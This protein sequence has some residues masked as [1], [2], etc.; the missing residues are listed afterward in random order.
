[1]IVLFVVAAMA[2]VAPAA[3]VGPSRNGCTWTPALLPL[4]P[5]ILDGQVTG[6]DGAW[7]AG[8][9]YDPNEGLLW[10]DG[11][12][13]THGRAFGLDTRLRTVNASGVAAGDVTGPDGRP[14][15]IRYAGRYEYLPETAGRSVALDVNGR[16]EIVGYDGVALV[17]WPASGPARVLAMP[18]GA[19]PYGSPSIDE[20][21]TVVV[22]TGTGDGQVMRWQAYAWLPSGERVPFAAGDVRDVLDVRDGW[23]VGV[24]GRSAEAAAGWSLGGGPARTYVGGV[25]A[26]AVNRTGV[27]VGAGAGGEP[28]L[29]SG[30]VPVPLPAP[31]GYYPG[32]VTAVNDHEAGGFVSP[33]NDLGTVPV[34]W[35]CRSSRW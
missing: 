18:P 13:A 33:A 27:V 26:A 15:A 8:V 1:M 35:S 34:R 6:G 3:A 28:L 22:R 19:A 30:F 31:P 5:G 10:Q 4:P 23:V 17:V 20:D 12:L 9:T 14:H 25:S 16:G 32:S 24:S 21:G 7:L 2:V 11:R 29:W